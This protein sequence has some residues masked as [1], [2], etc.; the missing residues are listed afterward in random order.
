[1]S[2]ELERLGID[3]QLTLIGEG[4]AK[5]DLLAML[6]SPQDPRSEIHNPTSKIAILPPQPPHAIGAHLAHSDIFVLASRYEGLSVSLLEAM[7][8]G[9][10]PVIS[11]TR[12]GAGEAVEDG[13]CGI[14]ADIPYH[15][16]D[17]AAGALMAGAVLRAVSAGLER[18]SANARA[19]VAGDFSMEAQAQ[20]AIAVMEAA[21]QGSPRAWPA[22]RPCAFTARVGAPGSGSVPPEGASAMARILGALAGKKVVLHGAGRHTLELAHVI[23]EAPAQVVAIADDDE[24][25]HGK[26]LLGWEI[27]PLRRA[28]ATGA[29][30]VVLSTWM[31]A[32]TL[33]QRRAEYERQ[34]LKVHRLY[35]AA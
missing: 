8:H 6:D 7:A 20:A 12:S 27:I 32:E 30:D 22:D 26:Q 31:H 3:H 4:P 29:T 15:A 24:S 11:R 13:E 23:A 2:S 19:K 10:V 1:M 34:G 28:H 21:V 14:V 16:T 35:P 25:K 18:L 33:W 17:A 5:D 9:C